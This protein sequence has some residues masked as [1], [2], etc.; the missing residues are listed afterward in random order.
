MHVIISETAEQLGAKAADKAAEVVR[1]AIE[2]RGQARIIVSTGASQFDFI[3]EFV[4]RDIDWSKVVMF[5]LDEYVAM[6]ETHPASFRK[7]LKERLLAFAPIGEVHFVDGE[8]DAEAKIAALSR[9]LTK[10]PID[11]GLIGI[12]ENA[13]IAFNDPPADFDATEAYRFVELNESCKRQQVR[14]GWFP[15]L[16][17]VPKIAITMT[18]KQIYAC[19][20]I[21]SCVPHAVKAEAIRNTLEGPVTNEVP[22]TYLRSHPDWRLYLDRNSA[23]RLAEQPGTTR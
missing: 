2:R 19:E 14:E 6:P 17:D 8:G 18:V 22:A 20:T 4:K 16:D 3:S 5:H 23:S 13:H 9:E 1:G 10:A 7:Y 12:G 21:I 15:T 11:L